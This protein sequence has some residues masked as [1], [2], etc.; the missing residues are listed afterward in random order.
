MK[1]Y[2]MLVC[3]RLLFYYCKIR[4]NTLLLSIS[5]LT[6]DRVEY[7]CKGKTMIYIKKDFLN[8]ANEL[9]LSY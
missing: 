1:N 9:F 2:F 4:V 3:F 6:M 5:K 7:S 8:E